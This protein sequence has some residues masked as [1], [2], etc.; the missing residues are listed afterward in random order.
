MPARIL[1]ALA[2]F[3]FAS[4]CG[5]SGETTEPAPS[6]E[7]SELVGVIASGLGGEAFT[8]AENTCLAESIVADLG[9]EELADMGITADGIP[10]N[11]TLTEAQ[12]QALIDSFDNGM[13]ECVDL[14]QVLNRAAGDDVENICVLDQMPDAQLQTMFALLFGRTNMTQQDIEALNAA[15]ERA[16]GICDPGVIENP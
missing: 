2:L 8:D 16:Q 1:I 11:N 15:T 4:G 5:G 10:D 12:D 14:R 6:P 7:R 13:Q 9:A 3:L